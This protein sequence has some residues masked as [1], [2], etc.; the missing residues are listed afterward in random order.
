MADSDDTRREVLDLLKDLQSH[1]GT[2]HNHKETVSWAGIALYAFLVVGIA[3]ALRESHLSCLARVG[4]S[5]LVLG[6]C[7]ICWLYVHKQFQ[8]RTR[9][10]DLVAAC[11]RLRSDI[12]S[13][14]NDVIRLSDWGPPSQ[15][16]LGGMQSTHVLPQA[17]RSAADELSSAGQ[18]SRQWLERCAYALLVGLT[19]SLLAFVWAAGPLKSLQLS[20]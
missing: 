2:Y 19:G 13:A 9:A 7:L 11:I 12:I 1:Y 16:F 20:I 6:A 8:L 18:S 3:N 5:F 17:V 14:P 10:A 15:A 4:V